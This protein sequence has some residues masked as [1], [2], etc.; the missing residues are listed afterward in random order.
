MFVGTLKTD[1]IIF[2]SNIIYTSGITLT[3]DFQYYGKFVDTDNITR[4]DQRKNVRLN[5]LY[6]VEEIGRVS[7]QE[8]HDQDDVLID[9]EVGE[10]DDIDQHDSQMMSQ[11]ISIDE[12]DPD[13]NTHGKY[14]QIFLKLK[15]VFFDSY[16]FLAYI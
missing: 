2:I 10:D 12:D 14:N 4:W 11:E 13:D 7:E 15:N 5:N 16:L 1:V 8:D 6:I 9:V 3:N